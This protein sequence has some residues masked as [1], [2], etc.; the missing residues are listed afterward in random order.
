MTDPGSPPGGAPPIVSPIADLTYRHYDGPLNSRAFRFWIVALVGIRQVMRKWWFWLLVLGSVW[1]YGLIGFFFFL[2]S[3]LGDDLPRTFLNAAPGAKYSTAFFQAF[4][5]QMFWLMVIGLSVGA[6]SIAADNKTNALQV[7]LAKP[8][9]KTD[10]LLGK[11]MG[12]FSVVFAAALLPALLLYTYCLLSFWSNGFLRQEP[13]LF[14]KILGASASAA[15][16][17][18]S[19]FIGVSAWSRSPMMAG[20][21]SAG[22]YFA[23]GIVATILW[24][25]LYGRSSASTDI[26]NA[27]L[28]QHASIGGVLKALV[29]NIYDVTVRMPTPGRMFMPTDVRAPS[30]GLVLVAYL[31]I[32]IGGLVAA[33]L[34]I[35]AVEVVTG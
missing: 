33:R 18:A 32:V 1:P 27:V 23:S 12:V 34:R 30:L 13:W 2:E 7:Y 9:T 14:F 21:F 5:W 29:W 35:R 20:A 3:R 17:F 8:I 4:D 26:T 6:A 11:W 31:A 22:M 25:A 19:L 10:Y 16:G 15:A 28:V 24:A